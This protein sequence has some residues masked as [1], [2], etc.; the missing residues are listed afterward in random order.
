MCLCGDSE[1]PSCGM[2][3]GTLE[4]LP[5]PTLEE[6]SLR[7]ERSMA[8]SDLIFALD[9]YPT[10][11]YQARDLVALIGDAVDAGIKIGQR[12]QGVQAKPEAKIIPLPAKPF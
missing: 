6:L 12:Y 11:R 1:C 4:V 9:T 3:Q 10:I 8:V 2:M 5:D 7:S